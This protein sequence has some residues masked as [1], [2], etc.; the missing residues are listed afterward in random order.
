[1]SDKALENLKK[2]KEKYISMANNRTDFNTISPDKFL[3][4]TLD[5]MM[6]EDL[7]MEINE[8]FV[9]GDTEGDYTEQDVLDAAFYKEAPFSTAPG[10]YSEEGAFVLQVKT[11][12]KIPDS[13]WE[14]N[15]FDGDTWSFSL[16][17]IND[18]NQSIMFTD[19]PNSVKYRNFKDF[20]KKMGGG[21]AIQIRA[22][23][24]DAMEIP[25][26]E[27][28]VCPNDLYKERIKKVT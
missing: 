16:E 14:L 15:K 1:M 9:N 24:I 19:G 13:S 20:F 21:S 27:V 6:Q 7:M 3:L 18:G 12:H 22:L 2:A 17:E 4:P 8:Q 25:H 26:Y 5:E 28:Q 23:G 11:P 10:H